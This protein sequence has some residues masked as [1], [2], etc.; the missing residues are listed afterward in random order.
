MLLVVIL[1]ICLLQEFACF[2]LQS[3]SSTANLIL[4]G[5][6]RAFNFQLMVG[7]TDTDC[8]QEGVIDQ[9]LLSWLLCLRKN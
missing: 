3:P 8:G 6:V 4:H 7:E 9:G 5:A 1:S 2:A